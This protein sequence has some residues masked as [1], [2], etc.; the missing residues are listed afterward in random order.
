MPFL[1]LPAKEAA[2]APVTADCGAIEPGSR[3]LENATNLKPIQGGRVRI[4][5]IVRDKVVK[6]IRLQY[7][8]IAHLKR[9]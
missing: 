4:V 7:T 2:L 3:A 5:A 1:P 8:I 9:R 6:D